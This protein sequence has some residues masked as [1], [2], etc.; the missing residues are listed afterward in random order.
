[1]YFLYYE[2][3]NLKMPR[4]DA[5]KTV[6]SHFSFAQYEIVVT[7]YYNVNSVFHFS[8]LL[9][10]NQHCSSDSLSERQSRVQCFVNLITNKQRG[11]FCTQI[12]LDFLAVI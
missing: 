9:F 11:I 6:R 8:L 12:V 7:N 5:H 10:F 3:M 2:E 1:M 4:L